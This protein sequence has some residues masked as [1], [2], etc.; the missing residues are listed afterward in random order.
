MVEKMGRVVLGVLARGA[1][2]GGYPA[3][4]SPVG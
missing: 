2:T 3:A 1:L 4:D